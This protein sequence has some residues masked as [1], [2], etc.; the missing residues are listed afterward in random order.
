MILVVSPVFAEIVQG[1]GTYQAGGEGTVTLNGEGT[2]ILTQATGTL[3]IKD[4]D[5]VNLVGFEEIGQG[6]HNSTIYEG[7][8]FAT[9]SGTNVGV[10]FEGDA[11]TI[12]GTGQGKVKFFGNGWWIAYKN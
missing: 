3:W 5:N 8:G 6:E 4:A 9:I 2:I 11:T 10:R 1:N 12:T 7:S